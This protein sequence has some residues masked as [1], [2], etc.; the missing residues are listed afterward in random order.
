RSWFR[1]VMAGEDAPS[2][3]QAAGPE[4]DWTGAVPD[5][6]VVVEAWQAWGDEVRYA[7]RYVAGVDD[8]GTLG[9]KRD[10]ST[11][12][13]RSVLVHMVEEYARHCGHADLLRERIDGR[14]GQ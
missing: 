10:G 14:V 12:P 3:Y 7:E 2:L 1:R 4:G 9:R 8:L 11:I 5:R 13:L 6:S